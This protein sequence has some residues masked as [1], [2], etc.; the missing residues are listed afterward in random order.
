MSTLARH[1]TVNTMDHSLHASASVP[2]ELS[3][4]IYPPRLPPPS[5]E[6]G[7]VLIKLSTM[8]R[9]SHPPISQQQTV[10][11]NAGSKQCDTIWLFPSFHTLGG[12]TGV[13]AYPS[14]AYLQ[15]SASDV[16]MPTV[17]QT[18]IGLNYCEMSRAKIVYQHYRRRR[19][20]RGDLQQPYAWKRW[21]LYSCRSRF[22]K[23]SDS[24]LLLISSS[25]H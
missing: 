24:P 4:Y 21:R 15:R 16:S 2:V 6:T 1:R 12:W 8:A 25:T 11:F 13:C 19:G 20:S 22:G 5:D 23:S 9:A 7:R 18:V 10:G 3:T 14:D 17:V